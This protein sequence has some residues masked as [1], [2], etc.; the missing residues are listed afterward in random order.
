MGSGVCCLV[1]RSRRRDLLSSSSRKA[2]F[3]ALNPSKGQET[4][5]ASKLQTGL[6]EVA[7]IKVALAPDQLQN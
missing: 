4:A 3:R 1:G 5:R 6:S 7:R 2:R